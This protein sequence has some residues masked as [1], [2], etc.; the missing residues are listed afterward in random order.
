MG[1]YPG[2]RRLLFA[3]L[4]LSTP[5]GARPAALS[6]VGELGELY[7]RARRIRTL[8][9]HDAARPLYDDILR[10]NPDDRTAATH[11]GRSASSPRRHDR[12]G[13]DAGELGR[14]GGASLAQKRAFGDRLREHRYTPEDIAT[15]VLGPGSHKGK[16]SSAPLYL[17]P[18]EAGSTA[19]PP[20]GCALGCLIQLFLLAA[21]VSA[22]TCR[23]WLGEEMCD[24]LPTLGIA[25]EDDGVIVPYCHIMPVDVGGETLYLATDLHPNVLSMTHVND[26]GAVMYI[27]PDSLALIDHWST[28]RRRSGDDS[29]PAP[30]SHDD[31]LVDLG[32]GSGIQALALAAADHRRGKAIKVTCVDINPRALRLTRLNF[33]WNRVPVPALVLGDICGPGGTAR[34]REVLRAPT[35][36]VANPPFLPVPAEDAA[37]ARRHGPFSDGGPAGD[38]VLRRVL[39]LAAA[40]LPP[41][42]GRLAVVSEFMNPHADLAGRLNSWWEGDGAAATE[43]RPPRGRALLVTNERPVDADAY[44]ERRGGGAALGG[45]VAAR[46]RAHLRRERISH[47]SPGL[48]FVRTCDG[49]EDQRGLD[50]RHERLPKTEQGSL[51]TP[52]N[53]AGRSFTRGILEESGF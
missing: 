40:L 52:T 34:W 48:L 43:R 41:T 4:F 27:G 50:I 30:S 51:W 53:R 47:V 8:R 19:P 23:Q 42:A 31:H 15:L 37:I 16:H 14:G 35:T 39:A 11:V 44:A 32:T 5:P 29:S 25:F 45:T 36:I 9:G 22:E 21:C 38:A 46:W 3:C 7:R 12:L 18:L 28:W 10:R 49:N 20:P 1:T 6:A 26:E 33:Q 24:L 2:Q 17:R 13:R